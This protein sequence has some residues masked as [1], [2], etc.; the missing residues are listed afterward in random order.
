MH[1][2]AQHRTLCGAFATE[3]SDCPHDVTHLPSPPFV[4]QYRARGLVVVQAR[5]HAPPGAQVCRRLRR[6]HSHPE[7][8]LFD[9]LVHACVRIPRPNAIFSASWD[10][11]VAP[12]VL[13]RCVHPVDVAPRFV[14]ARQCRGDCGLIVRWRCRLDRCVVTA[15]DVR[16]VFPSALACGALPAPHAF[17]GSRTAT[18]GVVLL[19][20]RVVCVMGL[21]RSLAALPRIGIRRIRALAAHAVCGVVVPTRQRRFNTSCV[22]P[23]PRIG[24]ALLPLFA[25]TG[26]LP[27]A[28]AR[29]GARTA[30][31]FRGD[32]SVSRAHVRAG[33]S[34]VG[35]ASGMPLPW[36]RPRARPRG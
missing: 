15:R 20:P 23:G 2:S 34:G 8:Y 26:A 10:T 21:W 22:A 14:R 3:A 31:C 19:G 16:F 11:A 30:A 7:T 9:C 4:G 5:S 25:R 12:C 35:V 28:R 32:P 6:E 13:L 29:P 27:C 17:F 36:A 18:R 1:D 24:A 33:G